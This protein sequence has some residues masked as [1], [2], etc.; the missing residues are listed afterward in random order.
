MPGSLSK[1]A[2]NGYKVK[3]LEIRNEKVGTLNK[4]HL[5]AISSGQR[6]EKSLIFHFK[7]GNEYHNCI[8]KRVNGRCSLTKMS[9]SRLLLLKLSCSIMI[10]IT[11]FFSSTQN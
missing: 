7:I 11:A 5:F 1:I 6:N 8:L 10:K 4:P 2:K 3:G 9:L